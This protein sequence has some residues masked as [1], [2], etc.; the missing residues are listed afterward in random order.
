MVADDY[1]KKG[2]AINLEL[3]KYDRAKSL[4]IHADLTISQGIVKTRF[5][6]GD[7]LNPPLLKINFYH[8]TREEND[9]NL[10]LTP[11]AN[12]DYSGITDSLV[13]GRYTVYIEPLNGEWKIKEKIQLPS[14]TAFKIKPY[15]K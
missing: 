10:K 2:K 6:K 11:N 12:G 1:Y 7:S 4:F 9:V 13:D 3:T 14:N 5:T 8:A 15:Y